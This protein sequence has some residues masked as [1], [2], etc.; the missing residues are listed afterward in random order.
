MLADNGGLTDNQFKAIIICL[1]E[2][3]L[4][5]LLLSVLQSASESKNLNMKLKHSEELFYTKF[6]YHRQII[7]I[8]PPRY[9]TYDEKLWVKNGEPVVNIVRDSEKKN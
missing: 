2:F 6:G 7:H 3:F 8:I 9:G 4:F 5:L 1:G